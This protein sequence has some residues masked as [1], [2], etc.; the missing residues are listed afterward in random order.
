MPAPK[1]T[2]EQKAEIARRY[3]AGEISTDLAKEYG[4]HKTTILKSVKKLF[5]PTITKTP[6][7]EQFPCPYSPEQLNNMYWHDGMSLVE[8][9]KHAQQF[10]EGREKPF[11]QRTVQRWFTKLKI[12]VRDLSAAQRVDKIK[13]KGKYKAILA[14]I[15]GW[16]KRPIFKTTYKHTAAQHRK[17]AEAKI[18]RRVT[19]QCEQCGKSRTKPPS[20]WKHKHFFC[21]RECFHK[22][23]GLQAKIRKIA[24]ITKNT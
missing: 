8:I 3:E 15:P 6:Y 1:L 2:L 19:R 10:F 17:I 24:N 4:V 21:G 7:V 20:E 11:A 18:A 9:G 12:G 13:N 16:K 22:W 14:T 5:V 23:R